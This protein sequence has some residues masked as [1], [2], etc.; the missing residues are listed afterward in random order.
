MLSMWC[1][2]EGRL[3]TVNG[4]HNCIKEDLALIREKA[5]CY[6]MLFLV[7]GDFMDG[8]SEITVPQKGP[9][10]LQVVQLKGEKFSHF[11]FTKESDVIIIEF[12]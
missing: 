6:R 3:R 4:K 5:F 10:L 9:W 12:G 7:F 8:V 11:H 2:L 1:L